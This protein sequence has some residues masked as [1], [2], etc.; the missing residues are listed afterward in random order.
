MSPE[1]KPLKTTLFSKVT[2]ILLLSGVPLDSVNDCLY[3]AF[4]P[5]V[6]TDPVFPNWLENWRKLH[7]KYVVERKDNFVEWVFVVGHLYC[8]DRLK[9]SVQSKMN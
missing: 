3:W 2:H 1:E 8:L 4:G 7:P 5:N 6:M 9:K